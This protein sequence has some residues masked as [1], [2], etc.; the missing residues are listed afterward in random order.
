MQFLRLR[1][2]DDGEQIAADAVSGGLH[3]AEGRIRRDRGV[4]RAAAGFQDVERDLGGQRVA[5]GGHALA[6]M[7]FRAGGEGAVDQAVGGHG[8]CS[9]QGQQEEAG[10]AHREVSIIRV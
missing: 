7:D 9:E 5:G 3:Q 1:I 6:G 8:R 4:D 10:K 2:P